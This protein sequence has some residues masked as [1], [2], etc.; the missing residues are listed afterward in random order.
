MWMSTLFLFFFL[1]VKQVYVNFRSFAFFLISVSCL[2]PAWVS[3]QLHVT[4]TFKFF[5]IWPYQTWVKLF[6]FFLDL[7]LQLFI[8]FFLWSTF[9]SFCSLFL[10]FSKPGCSQAFIIWSGCHIS[11]LFSTFMFVV[12]PF[13]SCIKFWFYFSG[14]VSFQ[15]SRIGFILPN[16]LT[17][18][19]TVVILNW[20]NNSFCHSAFQK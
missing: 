1:P 5:A 11:S 9:W 15:F 8:F 7:L 17:E 12:L 19:P 10:R 13:L 18:L 2:Y 16:K 3:F 20:S 4:I 6:A 14:I